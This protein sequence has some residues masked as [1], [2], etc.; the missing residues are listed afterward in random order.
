MGKSFSVILTDSSPLC[1]ARA[2]LHTLTSSGI[3]TTYI[4]LFALPS[5][6]SSVSKV[7]LGAHALHS[8]GALF[9]RAGTAL[10]AMMARS[11]GVPVLVCCET[12][13][14]SEGVNLDGF[15]KN[16]LGLFPASYSSFTI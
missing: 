16:E 6:L 4:P 15:T 11:R 3:P 12:Y 14:F 10:V 5:L 9:S 7:L 8:N 1:E 13:K 2:L